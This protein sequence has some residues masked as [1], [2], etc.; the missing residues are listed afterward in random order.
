[1]HTK[2]NVIVLIHIIIFREEPKSNKRKIPEHDTDI[3]HIIIGTHRVIRLFVHVFYY[4]LVGIIIR[5]ILKLKLYR[6]V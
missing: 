6:V 4:C 5:T 2:Y 1:V 3:I